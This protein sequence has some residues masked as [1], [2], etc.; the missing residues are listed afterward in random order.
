MSIINFR[1]TFESNFAQSY[2]VK[3]RNVLV[4]IN[5]HKT[6]FV[7]VSEFLMSNVQKNRYIIHILNFELSPTSIV[8]DT[9]SQTCYNLIIFHYFL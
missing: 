6:V 3:F 4:R 7:F 9:I 5:T 8:R 2:Y 1:A